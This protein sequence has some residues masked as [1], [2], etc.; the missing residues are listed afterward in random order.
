LTKK[1]TDWRKPRR[2][3][4]EGNCVE[5]ASGMRIR[6]TKDRDGF[7]LSVP[8]GAWRVFVVNVKQDHNAAREP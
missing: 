7:V 2:S 4:S 3:A 6:D 5:V 8:A 1:G